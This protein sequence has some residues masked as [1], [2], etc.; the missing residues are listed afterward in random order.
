MAAYHVLAVA[1]DC[2]CRQDGDDRYRDHQ[3]DQREPASLVHDPALATLAETFIRPT[4]PRQTSPD[5]RYSLGDRRHELDRIRT[6]PGPVC[7]PLRR[8]SSGGESNAWT[9]SARGGAG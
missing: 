1:R 2:D 5:K 4:C 3:L 8:R 6:R 9:C 7:E